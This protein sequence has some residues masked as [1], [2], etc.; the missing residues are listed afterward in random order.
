MELKPL[1]S[2]MVRSEFANRTFAKYAALPS[3]LGNAKTVVRL[4]KSSRS[5]GEATRKAMTRE[6]FSLPALMV[7]FCDIP[8][9]VKT[10]DVGVGSPRFLIGFW[11]RAKAAAA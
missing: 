1:T 11:S 5:T 8:E 10:R 2:R 7:R 4:S 3:T 9:K 6:R